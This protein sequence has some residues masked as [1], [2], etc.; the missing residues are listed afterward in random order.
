MKSDFEFEQVVLDD[1]TQCLEDRPIFDNTMAVRRTIK[2]EVAAAKA[3]ALKKAKAAQ[4]KASAD[5]VALEAVNK[6]K[7]DIK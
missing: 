4:L 5:V 6:G 1:G 7:V 3:K 2:A